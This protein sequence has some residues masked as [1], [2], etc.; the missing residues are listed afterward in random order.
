M[1][2]YAT[3]GEFEVTVLLAVLHVR[4][5]AYSS[6]VREE[7]ERRCGRAVAR[8][9]VSITLERLREKGLLTA[10]TGAASPARGNRPRR[11]FRVTAYG[12]RSLKQSLAAQ[13]SMLRGLEPILGDL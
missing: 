3:L 7:I 8:G 4:E 9:A 1:R 13:A 5:E 10:S 11:L 2:S 12:M 6:A